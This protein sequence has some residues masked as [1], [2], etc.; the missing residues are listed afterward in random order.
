LLKA[1][2]TNEDFG[3]P[4]EANPSKK[5]ITLP[6]TVTLLNNQKSISAQQKIGAEANKTRKRK[7]TNE[8]DVEA[9]AA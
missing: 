2:L 3:I 4:I 6:A 7:R 8:E 1:I 9:L 5:P